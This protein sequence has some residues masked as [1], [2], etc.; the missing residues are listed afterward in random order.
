MKTT[1]KIFLL[2][3][4][5]GI[6]FSAQAQNQNKID[7]LM[8]ALK[9]AKEDTN[10]VNTLNTLSKEDWQTSY[11]EEAKKYAEEALQLSEKIKYKKGIANA[12]HNMG[13]AYDYQGN[14]PEALKNYFLSLKTEEEIGNK[15][16]ISIS[17]NNIGIIYQFQGNY[18]RSVKKL[19]RFVKNKRRSWR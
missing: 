7:S 15:K 12:S 17:Y 6:V 11:Y 1:L 16:G 9:T 14:Y 8:N 5:L 18:P 3:L 13:T 4:F 10:K 2:T 19:F